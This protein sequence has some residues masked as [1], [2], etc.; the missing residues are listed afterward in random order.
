MRIQHLC[1]GMLSINPAGPDSSSNAVSRYLMGLMCCTALQDEIRAAPEGSS[2]FVAFFTDG[3][4]TS[5]WILL[6]YIGVEA[7]QA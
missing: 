5:I 3:Q 2:F 7:L 4:V 6:T 1:E